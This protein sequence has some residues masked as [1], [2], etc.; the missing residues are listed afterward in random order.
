[1]HATVQENS[2]SVT[3]DMQAKKLSA[4]VLIKKRLV[5]IYQLYAKFF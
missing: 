5:K 2:L 4:I 1:M 3:G